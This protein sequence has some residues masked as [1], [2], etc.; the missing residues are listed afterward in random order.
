MMI[1]RHDRRGFS[2]IEVM[3]SA[4]LVSV[5]TGAMVYFYQ[6]GNMSVVKVSDHSQARIEAIRLLDL[7]ASDLE[8][9]VVDDD[10]RNVVFPVSLP[11]VGEQMEF[12]ALHHREY[13]PATR[14]LKLVGRKMVYSVEPVGGGQPGLWVLRNGK[15]VPGISPV[16]KITFEPLDDR[17]ACE[18]AISPFHAINI[19]IIP[20]GSWDTRNEGLASEANEQSRLVHLVHIESQYACLLSIKKANPPPGAYPGIER[21][22]DLFGGRCPQVTNAPSVPLD[23]VRPPG[24]VRCEQEMFDD[25]TA[26]IDVLR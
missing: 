4:I 3:I 11:G 21:L 19:R 2:L 15:R 13:D 8:K 7:I 9:A 16:T 6:M 14:Q 1:T 5:F 23:W 22:E 18:L 10:I 26:N 20:R 25:A 17:R 12:S 24:L